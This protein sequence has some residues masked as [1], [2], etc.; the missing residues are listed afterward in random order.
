MRRYI[1]AFIGLVIFTVRANGLV[2]YV[3]PK[4]ELQDSVVVVSIKT[5]TPVTK[6]NVYYD[7]FEG[8]GPYG[9]YLYNLYFRND[10]SDTFFQFRMK[11]IE[12]YVLYRYIV[13][14]NNERNLTI[15]S[16]EEYFRLIRGGDGR[17]EFGLAYDVLPFVGY[18]GNGVVAVRW[19]LTKDADEAFVIVYDG[20]KP[21]AQVGSAGKS[22]EFE[23]DI[24]HLKP[25][26]EYTYMTYSIAGDDTLKLGGSF[27]TPKT[28]GHDF[29]FVMMGDSRSNW[30]WPNSVD[31]TNY[32]AASSLNLLARLLGRYDHDFVI[33]SGDLI[34]GGTTDALQALEQY[35]TWLSAVWA[36]NRNAFYFN[37]VGNHDATAPNRR[38]PNGDYVPLEPPNCSE[39]YWA[40]MYVLPENGPD[41]P[42]GEAPYTENT[43]SFD[44]GDVHFVVINDDYGYYRKNK[45][46]KP[47]SLTPAQWRWLINDLEANKGKWIIVSYHEP[48]F[49][50]LGRE[51]FDSTQIDSLWRVFDRYGVTA[52]VNGHEHIYARMEVDS[53]LVKGMKGSIT[54]IISGRAGAPKYRVHRK[55]M[56]EKN[57]RKIDN[58]RHFV[59]VHASSDS[60]V[61]Q[62]VDFDGKV[63]DRWVVRKK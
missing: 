56:F 45:H 62:A 57:L 31:H 33:F 26:K 35:K 3:F 52:V 36:D 49:S 6:P 22:K 30:R 17:L 15:P 39:C 8:D 11:H 16:R 34:G 50:P 7:R 47:A 46:R 28:H 20:D 43:Y 2:R 51:D 58:R 23:F 14:V 1:G 59:L 19:T 41:A 4:L 55:L 37:V 38:L 42:D 61:F 44:W 18:K 54:Q 12:P 9:D 60:L 5:D 13:T 21:I 27:R 63:F 53:S 40:R 24:R 29:S 10:T 25:N 32:V 48:T